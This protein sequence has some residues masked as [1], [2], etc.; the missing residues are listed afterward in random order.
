M[1]TTAGARIVTGV[2]V[3]AL[4]HAAGGVNGFF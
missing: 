1:A 2:R 4:E 3:N